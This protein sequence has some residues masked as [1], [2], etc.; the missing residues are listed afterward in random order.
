[1]GRDRKPWELTE[2]D[3][4]ALLR[5]ERVMLRWLCGFSYPMSGKDMSNR[6]PHWPGCT[7]DAL[8]EKGLVRRIPE[9]ARRLMLEVPGP[10]ELGDGFEP[11][12]DGRKLV[13]VME[14][15]DS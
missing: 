5:D 8:L 7:L 15:M 1:M 2:R 9:A 10:G 6:I 3:K 13:T 12:E 11:T 4:E 14:V